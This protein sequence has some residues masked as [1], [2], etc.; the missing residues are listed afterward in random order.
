MFHLV[1]L[2][3]V[4]LLSHFVYLCVHGS[5]GCRT[6]V[7][8]DSGVCPLVGEAGLKGFGRLFSGRNC[9]LPTFWWTETC[10]DVCLEVCVCVYVREREKVKG[11]DLCV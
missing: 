4:P 5:I 8:L 11:M 7:P 6:V 3:H 9:C 10:Q 2:E 1:C